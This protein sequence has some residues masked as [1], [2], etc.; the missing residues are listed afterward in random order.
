MSYIER[1]LPSLGE[2]AVTLRPIGGVAAD[3]VRLRGERL[4][5]PATAAVKGSL[6]MAKLLRRLA[7]EPPA[8]GPTELRLTIKGHVLVLPGR[9]LAEI[10]SEALGHHKLNLGRPAAE[11]GLLNALW[12]VRPTDLDQ[13]RDEFDDMVTDTAIFERFLDAWWPP[14]RRD[15][16]PPPARRRRPGPPAVGRPAVQR[17]VRPAGRQLRRPR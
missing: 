12:R 7:Y 5:A 9:V 11:R 14:G 15:R 16:R 8:D 6:R 17:R 10:R 3:V 13:E 1:V 2:D 4:D